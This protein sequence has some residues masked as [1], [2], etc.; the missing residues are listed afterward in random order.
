MWSL[1]DHASLHPTLVYETFNRDYESHLQA[2]R[3][4]RRALSFHLYSSLKL[5][6]SYSFTRDLAIWRVTASRNQDFVLLLSYVVIL[7][8]LAP[9]MAAQCANPLL[10]GFLKEWWDLARDQSSKGAAT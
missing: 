2:H 7:R 6:D 3:I 8:K 5:D 9:A 10:L 1:F 4:Y